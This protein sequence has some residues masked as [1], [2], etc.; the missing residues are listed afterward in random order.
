M[1]ELKTKRNKASV[2]AFV[3]AIEDEGRRRDCKRLSALIK[4]KHM[5]ALAA[6]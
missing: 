4:V 6:E 3:A 1:A 2:A 5:R